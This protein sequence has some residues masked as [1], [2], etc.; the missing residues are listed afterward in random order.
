M[1]GIPADTRAMRQTLVGG[2]LGFLLGIL[3]TAGIAAYVIF[4]YLPHHGWW[5]V[6]SAALSFAHLIFLG[7]L[8]AAVAT[9]WVLD[10]RH[11]ARGAYRCWRCNRALA[12]KVP[13]SCWGATRRLGPRRGRFLRHYRRRIPELLMVG[14]ALLPAAA[15][16]ILLIP[17]TGEKP[18]AVEVII[19]HAA[20]SMLAGAGLASAI[21]AMESFKCAK[22]FRLWASIF[23]RVLL[24]WGFVVLVML[25][26]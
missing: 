14:A 12:R 22:R 26:R 15:L 25:A 23:M 4:H 17:V 2:C 5:E 24:I 10:R 19:R 3:G 6:L 16:L 1:T 8:G 9:V 11:Y 20:L 18:L 7:G 21:M 13:C